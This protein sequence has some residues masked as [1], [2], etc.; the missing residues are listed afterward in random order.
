[1]S[2]GPRKS[3]EPDGPLPGAA[4]EPRWVHQL[5]NAGA[6]RAVGKAG[7][8]SNGGNSTPIQRTHFG[9]GAIAP[10]SLVQLGLKHLKRITSPF[11]NNCLMHGRSHNASVK[12]RHS[13]VVQ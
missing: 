5:P 12:H 10:F 4:V 1:M 8:H 13:S 11:E 6:E 7:C 3:P 2:S 9:S